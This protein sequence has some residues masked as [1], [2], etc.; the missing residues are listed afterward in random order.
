MANEIKEIS[1]SNK[2]LEISVDPM[3]GSLLDRTYTPPLSENEQT[4]IRRHTE[5]T[6]VILKDTECEKFEDWFTINNSA[7]IHKKENDTK[8]MYFSDPLFNIV[9]ATNNVMDDSWRFLKKAG[10]I[11][12]D[13]TGNSV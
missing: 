13:I 9:E 6:D 4:L 7:S 11:I 1:E 8:K 5:S 2:L 12:S 3:P 10:N